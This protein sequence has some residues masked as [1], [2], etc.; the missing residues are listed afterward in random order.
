MLNSISEQ[1]FISNLDLVR[2]EGTNFSY[3]L[4]TVQDTY[5]RCAYSLILVEHQGYLKENIE[6]YMIIFNHNSIEADGDRA[7]IDKD[8]LIKKARKEGCLKK[9]DDLQNCWDTIHKL[10][11]A[12]QKSVLA[13]LE[14][15]YTELAYTEMTKQ[16][17]PFRN[18]AETVFLSVMKKDNDKSTE[19][20]KIFDSL[21][22]SYYRRTDK[23]K[24]TPGIGG[25]RGLP[26]PR[27]S[28]KLCDSIVK[29]KEYDFIYEDGTAEPRIS[30]EG[31]SGYYDYDTLINNIPEEIIKI[32]NTIPRISKQIRDDFTEMYNASR[33]ELARKE[34]IAQFL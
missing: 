31:V 2:L 21:A 15:E 5:D 4:K 30:I 8:E 25:H 28:T 12:E 22:Q 19:D 34:R 9:M 13:E 24:F 20:S 33:K 27:Q 23:R 17:G 3:E 18:L 14:T 10:D 32:M 1:F 16:K 11:D 7:V 26:G 29:I 6:T